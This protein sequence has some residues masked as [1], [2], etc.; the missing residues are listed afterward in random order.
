MGEDRHRRPGNAGV[1]AEVVQARE[2]HWKGHMW[3]PGHVNFR[4]QWRSLPTGL[5]QVET[6]VQRCLGPRLQVSGG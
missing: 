2:T 5:P 6:G 3:P 4:V 1:L